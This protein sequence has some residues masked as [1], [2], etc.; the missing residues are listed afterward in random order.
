M[1]GYNSATPNIQMEASCDDCLSLVYS[2]M[3][4]ILKTFAYNRPNM[5]RNGP[6]DPFSANKSV[7][8]SLSFI[9]LYSYNIIK[10]VWPRNL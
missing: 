3:R 2:T 4:F 7:D 8:F 10:Q 9:M 5:E 6:Y 1:D